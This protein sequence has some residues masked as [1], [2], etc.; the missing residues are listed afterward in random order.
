M[1]VH[2]P[3][4]TDKHEHFIKHLVYI[5]TVT[6]RSIGDPLKPLINKLMLIARFAIS[7]H[8]GIAIN[9]RHGMYRAYQHMVHQVTDDKSQTARY[10]PV[11]QLTGTRTSRYRAVPLK[12][13]KEI[14]RQ[15][16]ICPRAIDRAGEEDSLFFFLPPSADTTRNQPATIKIDCYRSISRGNERKQP[17]PSGTTQYCN[18]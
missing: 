14:A 3:K 15:R 8:T 17:L 10:I 12:S 4:D 9:R 5:L 6:A 11:R 1:Y 2:K 13:T 16:R 18:P 7:Y